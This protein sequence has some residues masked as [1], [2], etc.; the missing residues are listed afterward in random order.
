[1]VIKY[2]GQTL[3]HYQKKQTFRKRNGRELKVVEKLAS[4][5]K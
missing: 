5:V 2:Q 4:T 3:H 1:M